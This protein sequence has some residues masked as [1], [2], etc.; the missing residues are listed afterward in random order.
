MQLATEEQ[1]FGIGGNNP[2]SPIEIAK[3][4]MTALS[5]WMKENPVIQEHKIA[6]EGRLLCD[7]AKI[8]LEEMEID[9]DGKVRP[10]NQQVKSINEEYRTPRETLTKVL[11]ELKSRLQK[12][13]EAEEAKRQAEAE[14]KTRLAFEAEQKA[15]DA[16]A[17]H[18]E[19]VDNAASGELGIDV[20]TT[21]EEAQTA[22][23]EY[24]RAERARAI[25]EKDSHVKLNGGFGRAMSL[26]TKETLILDDAFKALA[27]IGVTEKIREAILS[28]AR[29]YRKIN[30]RLPN[31]VSVSTSQSV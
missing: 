25:A 19:A 28:D 22:Y 5:D 24:E 14:E 11:D 7:R 10:L 6:K 1:R 18:Q 29:A 12:F 8:S 31:G 16:I 30:S 26:K 20:A 27:E 15:R 4:T 9:R 17:K 2:P 21:T 3:G 23:N 13:I